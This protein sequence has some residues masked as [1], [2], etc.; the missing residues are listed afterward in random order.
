TGRI[1]EITQPRGGYIRPTEFKTIQISDNKILGEENIHASIIGMVVDYLTRFIMAKC[2]TSKERERTIL[3]K[4]FE[5]SIKGYELRVKLF[6]EKVLKED[7]KQKVDLDSLLNLINGLD[8]DSIIAACKLTTYD[9]WY[10]NPMSA[11]MAKPAIEINPDEQ[12]IENIRIMINRCIDFWKNYGPIKVDGFTFE[13]DG[14][15]K[16]VNAGDGD[17]L[18]ADTLWDFKVTNS[19]LTNK[20]TLQLLM[21]WIMGQHSKKPEFK[22]ITKLGI[23]N[24]RLNIVYIYDIKCLSKEII[25]DIEDNVICY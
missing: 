4:A 18:T 16:T 3:E 17:F 14:Y 10:R 8:N 22:N 21:Y 12:T 20:H 6:G 24:P 7:K 13:K 1:K 9:V 19:K 23:F 5:I 2:T 11:I 15:T 25:K